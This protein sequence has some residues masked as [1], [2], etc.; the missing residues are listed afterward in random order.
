MILYTCICRIPSVLVWTMQ[1][2]QYVLTKNVH[3]QSREEITLVPE[4]DVAHT[5]NLSLSPSLAQ[6][7][8]QSIAT[9]S[10][11]LDIRLQVEWLVLK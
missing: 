2:K 4:V 5:N 3:N 1:E 9:N 7:M 6:L 10:L 8:P 11:H